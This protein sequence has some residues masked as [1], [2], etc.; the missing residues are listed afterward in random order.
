[1]AGASE[2]SRPL[3]RTSATTPTI[4]RHCADCVALTTRSR[5]PT[6]ERPSNRERA[7]RSLTSTTRSEVA[8]SSG[9]KARPATRR[10]PSAGR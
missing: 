5:S 10:V 3:Y 4:V 7:S 8:V 6:G 9:P 1:M 2:S